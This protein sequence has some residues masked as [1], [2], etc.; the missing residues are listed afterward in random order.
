MFFLEFFDDDSMLGGSKSVP[1]KLPNVGRPASSMSKPNGNFKLKPVVSK[2]TVPPKE[3][4]AKK[5]IIIK[6]LA[7]VAIPSPPNPQP[8]VRT[9]KSVTGLSSKSNEVKEHS[10][11]S[12]GGSSD[13]Q[14]MQVN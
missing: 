8:A 7:P 1:F 2:N 5:P 14:K 9:S 10:F 13:S 4:M 3:V 6:K 12:R 11:Q